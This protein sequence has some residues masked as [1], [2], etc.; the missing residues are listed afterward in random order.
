MTFSGIDENEIAREFSDHVAHRTTTPTD[1]MTTR[2]MG[3]GPSFDY[4]DA[5][6]ESPHL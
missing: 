4:W 3:P 1:E 5:L 6:V 2:T